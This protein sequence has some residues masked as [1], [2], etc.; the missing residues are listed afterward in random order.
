MSTPDAIAH[1]PSPIPCPPSPITQLV[2]D[3]N[4]RRLQ[5]A[6]PFAVFEAKDGAWKWQAEYSG[7]PFRDGRGDIF[8]EVQR[9]LRWAR[10]HIG[11]QGA[12]IGFLSYDAAR[13]IEPRAFGISSPVDDLQIPDARLVFYEKLEATNIQP[14]HH[15]PAAPSLITHH[16]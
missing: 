5:G 4:G 9:A 13:Q 2:L 14:L 11:S 6:R 3:F 15:Y 7:F 16:S 12:A 8:N 10:S 1:P